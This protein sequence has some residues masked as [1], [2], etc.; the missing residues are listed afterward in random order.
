MDEAV[1]TERLMAY[2]TSTPEGIR[3]GAEFVKAWFEAREVDVRHIDHHGLPV[4]IA[5]SGPADGPVVI[6]HGHIDVVPAFEH[7]F[8]PEIDGDRLVGRGAYDMKGGLAAMMCAVHDAAA[9]DAV[10]LRFVCVP[11][12]ESED[13][14][15]RSTDALVRD[16]T[17]HADFA[18]TGE[19][20][21]L[22]IGVQAKGVLAIRVEV[23]GLAAHGSTPW[24]GDN[25][26]LKSHDVFRR[27]ETLPFS[28]ES[29]DLFD[30]PSINLARIM[31]GDAFNKVPDRCGMDVDIRYLPGQDPDEIL[32]QVAD[33]PDVEILRSFS[34]RPAIV[35]RENVFVL[36]LRDAVSR[37]VEG[38]ALSIGRDGASDAISFLEAGIPAVEFG[39]VGGG[40]HGPEEWVSIAS[41]ARY[42]RALRDFVLGLPA[43]LGGAGTAAP[44]LRAVDGGAS[45]SG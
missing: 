9:Q 5:E 33:L 18:I 2:D 42:R 32:R 4:L 13:V 10:R 24:L 27:I 36:A 19:P 37:S 29:S 22:H 16:G 35:S 41:L 20:T 25:A 23:S 6:L 31:G 28:R 15:D 34:R 30:R 12:E 38:E 17:L 8:T 39:P 43:H 14:D 7:Q 21:D 40:H 26:I 45:A 3:A 1:L 44:A 11:D